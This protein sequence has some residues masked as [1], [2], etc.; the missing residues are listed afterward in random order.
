MLKGKALIVLSVSLLVA[1][2]GQ[3]QQKDTKGPTLTALDYA[4]IQKLHA[5]Y[6]LGTDMRDGTMRMRSFAPGGVLA[7]PAGERVARA[8]DADPKTAPAPNVG[9][10]T[11]KN[12]ACV[13]LHFTTDMLIEPSPEGAK[14]MAHVLIVEFEP[15]STSVVVEGTGIYEDIFVKGPQGWGIKKRVYYPTTKRIS[16]ENGPAQFLPAPSNAPP[17]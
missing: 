5:L 7:T 10:S 6:I 13:R 17:K 9:C 4:E 11:S 8:I 2:A 3:A 15:G 12:P 1:T 16:S 14:G